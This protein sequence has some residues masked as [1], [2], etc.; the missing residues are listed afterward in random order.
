MKQSDAQSHVDVLNMWYEPIR[1]ECLSDIVCEERP[2]G[3]K[4]TR[5]V[6]LKCKCHFSPAIDS[7]DFNHLKETERTD[8]DDKLCEVIALCEAT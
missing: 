6:L 5:A 7:V 8:V 3:S 1:A 4:Q 2:Y